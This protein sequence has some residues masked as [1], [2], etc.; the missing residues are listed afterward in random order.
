MT[1]CDLGWAP[2]LFQPSAAASFSLRIQGGEEPV[3]GSGPGATLSTEMDGP[4]EIE[5]SGSIVWLYTEY[6]CI[7]K[8]LGGQPGPTLS[9]LP[10]P[11]EGDI[12]REGKIFGHS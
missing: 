3:G 7:S 11:S 12:F 6:Q 2:D 10:G 9:A 4:L 5:G 8:P 1:Y